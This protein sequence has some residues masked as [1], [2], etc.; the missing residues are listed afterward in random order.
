MDAQCFNST[1]VRLKVDPRVPY[2][3]EES[4]FQFHTG[5]IKSNLRSLA[6]HNLIS[7]QFHTGSIKSGISVLSPV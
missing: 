2:E 1:L 3:D 7:F 6:Y 4:T 5:S